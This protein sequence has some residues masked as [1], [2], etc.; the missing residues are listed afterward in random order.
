MLME[1]SSISPIGMGEVNVLLKK[2]LPSNS[3]QEFI[4]FL[5][6]IM[7]FCTRSLACPRIFNWPE[8]EVSRLVAFVSLK[9]RQIYFL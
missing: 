9:K 2:V 7:V 8:I 1:N 6:I 5:E 4:F 3:F